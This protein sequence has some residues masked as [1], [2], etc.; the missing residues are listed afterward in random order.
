[1]LK[2]KWNNKEK[3]CKKMKLIKNNKIGLYK[4]I[5][6]EIFYQHLENYVINWERLKYHN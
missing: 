3:I 5:H 6:K 1:M 4:N 2:S